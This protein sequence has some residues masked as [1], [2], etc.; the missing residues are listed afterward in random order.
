MTQSSAALKAPKQET[1]TRTIE[2]TDANRGFGPNGIPGPNVT[3][4]FNGQPRTAHVAVALL[5]TS[6]IDIDALKGRVMEVEMSRG[7]TGLYQIDRIVKPEL[8]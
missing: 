7:R 4:S 8:L 3:L 6:G 5:A 1:Q 2:V